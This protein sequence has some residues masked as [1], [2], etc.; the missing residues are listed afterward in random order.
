MS[1]GEEMRTSLNQAELGCMHT[2]NVFESRYLIT[3][4]T[5]N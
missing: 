3:M 2:F 5:E 4:A 1:W